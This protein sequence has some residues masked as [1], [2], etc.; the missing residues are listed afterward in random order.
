MSEN[1]FSEEF[2]VRWSD[3]DPNQHLRH[4]AYADLCAATRL[5]YLHSLGFNQ[6]RFAKLK[7]G[8]ILFNENLQ[9]KK[10]VVANER[11]KVNVMIAGVSKDGRKWKIRHHITRVSDQEL[12]AV[13]DVSG[14]WF[15]VALR[16]VATPPRELLEVITDLPRTSD[17]QEIP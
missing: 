12:C 10:E 8:P 7:I 3:L 9:Y 6:A 11:V 13:V 16:R 15:D 4:S 1:I 5:S 2:Q 17:F 14:A